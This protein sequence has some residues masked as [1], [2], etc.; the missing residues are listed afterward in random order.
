METNSEQFPAERRP[1][2]SRRTEDRVFDAIQDSDHADFANHD[3]QPNS[4]TPAMDF[5]IS[6]PGVGHFLVEVKGGQY[7]L[8]RGQRYLEALAGRVEKPSQ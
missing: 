5:T 8:K 6:L 2:P 4:E 1:D 7:S 3:G